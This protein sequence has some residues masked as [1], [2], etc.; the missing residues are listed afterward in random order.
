[1]P[2]IQTNGPSS[3]DTPRF[4]AA[5]LVGAGARSAM[6]V[7]RL[8]ILI[9]LGWAVV[10]VGIPLGLAAYRARRPAD[11]QAANTAW[12]NAPA[13]PFGFYHGWWLGC[14]VDPD[15]QSNRCRLYGPGLNPPT[16]YEGRYLPCEGK[17]PVPVSELKIRPLNDSVDMWLR[18]KGV[19]VLLQDG[20]L[21][22]PAENYEDCTNIRARLEDRRELLPPMS[23]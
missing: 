23:R 12:V 8:L 17:S 3:C 22:V 2:D 18:P 14:W 19:A 6:R 13:V 15:Q 7:G 9:T 21:L 1:M 20:R 4:M 16:V 11:M 5:K 10:L